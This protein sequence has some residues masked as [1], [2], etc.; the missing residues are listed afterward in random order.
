MKKIISIITLIAL[1]FVV[2][3]SFVFASSATEVYNGV[4]PVNPNEQISTQS[5]SKPTKTWNT[6]S[7][8]AYTFGGTSRYQTLYTN[9][10]FTGNENY[11]VTVDNSGDYDIKVKV[12]KTFSIKTKTIKPNSEESFTVEGLN[13]TDKIYISFDGSY[14]DFS[15]TISGWEW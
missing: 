4:S 1:V 5:T 11:T 9:Y 14:M 3:P 6:S 7:K 12:I 8:G 2:S 13:S 10:K 15:G